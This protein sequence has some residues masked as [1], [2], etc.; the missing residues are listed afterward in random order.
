VSN[1]TAPGATPR[2]YLKAEWGQYDA[3]ISPDGKWAAFTSLESGT[4]EV[5]VR[6]FPAADAGGVV[7]VSSGGGQFARWSGDGHTIYYHALDG[8]TIRA[9]HVIIGGSVSVGATGTVMIVPGLGNGWDV[10]RK[11]GKI[12]VTQA[13]GGDPA[14]IV[15]M[16]H[17]LDDFRRSLAGKR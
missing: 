1:P 3:A 17:W 12:Y 2:T 7:K 15:V 14:R 10:D 9:V 16:Q 6:P 13:V 4:P 8:K 11:S 5:F